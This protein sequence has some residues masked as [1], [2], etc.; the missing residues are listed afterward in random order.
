MYKSLWPK[1]Q[2]GQSVAQYF[3]YLILFGAQPVD[4]ANGHQQRQQLWIYD[5]SIEEWFLVEPED[6]PLDKQAWPSSF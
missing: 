1:L 4:D 5:T 3:G 2:F 6:T